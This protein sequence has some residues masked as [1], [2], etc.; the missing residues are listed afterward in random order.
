MSGNEI[1]KQIY[2]ICRQMD[3]PAWIEIK[4]R[5]FWCG[6]YRLLLKERNA[7]YY[8]INC[9]AEGPLEEVEMELYRRVMEKAPRPGMGK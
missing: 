2:S 8:C 3:T 6:E 4:V 5:C 9:G 7:H 1:R